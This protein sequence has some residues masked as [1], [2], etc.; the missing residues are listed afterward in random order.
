MMP[1]SYTVHLKFRKFATPKMQSTMQRFLHN[2]VTVLR[3]EATACSPKACSVLTPVM[4]SV[5]SMPTKP[6]MASLQAA[7]AAAAA[8]APEA[9][10]AV[11]AAGS[12]AVHGV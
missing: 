6:S 4:A 3:L 9:P 10:A 1:P 11:T 2:P 8:A 7:A 5:A 12:A